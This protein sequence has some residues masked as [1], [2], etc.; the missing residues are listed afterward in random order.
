MDFSDVERASPCLVNTPHKC[1]NFC[2]KLI[3]KFIIAVFSCILAC[4][5]F[6]SSVNYEKPV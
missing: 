5:L 1:P 3:Y 4:V 6:S 2:K